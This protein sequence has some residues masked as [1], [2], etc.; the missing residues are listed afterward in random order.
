LRTDYVTDAVLKSAA[1]RS[2]EK[3][4]STVQTGEGK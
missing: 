3:V 1:N 4:R 2:W